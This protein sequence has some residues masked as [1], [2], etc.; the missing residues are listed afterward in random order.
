MNIITC[1]QG[2]PEWKAARAGKITGSRMP[3]VMTK[4]KNGGDSKV[5]TS[6]KAQII[7]EILTGEPQDDLFI[8]GPMRRGIELE[9]F[10]RAAYEMKTDVMVDQVGF[11]IHPNVTRLGCSPDGLVGEEGMVEFK[12]PLPATHIKYLLEGGAPE[13]YQPQLLT[14]L[15]VCE[16]KWNDF[17]SFCPEM[18]EGL[19]LFIVRFDRDGKRIAE[20]EDAAIQFNREVDQIV[21]ELLS[22]QEAA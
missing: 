5:R 3:D 7:A 13:E 9:P 11:V 4:L 21:R 18:P 22:K 14:E 17:V 10:A 2:T 19:Q 12:C 1:V 20:I 8:S 16:R 6:Y 15:A